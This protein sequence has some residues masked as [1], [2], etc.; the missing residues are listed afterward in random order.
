MAAMP[1]MQP[2]RWITQWTESFAFCAEA[3]LPA[4]L[5]WVL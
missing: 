5:G 3:N 4:F 1:L 2:T